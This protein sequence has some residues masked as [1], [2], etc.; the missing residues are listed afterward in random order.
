MNNFEY[1]GLKKQIILKK[2]KLSPNFVHFKQSI[3]PGSDCFN[4][5]WFFAMSIE[6]ILQQETNDV[7]ERATSAASSERLSQ[8]VT[9]E[10]C[11]EQRVIFCN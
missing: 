6:G 9:D 10:F 7:L 2:L 3:I 1:F 8:R 4:E 11:N 5:E